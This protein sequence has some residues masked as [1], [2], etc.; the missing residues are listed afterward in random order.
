MAGIGLLGFQTACVMQV[1]TSRSP[2]IRVHELMM[3]STYNED[4]EV[5]RKM[6]I[7]RRFTGGQNKLLLYHIDELPMK[8]T[9]SVK[10][11]P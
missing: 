6:I 10:I 9:N 11:S 3:E 2:S 4:Q 1:V 5:G 7:L 8:I